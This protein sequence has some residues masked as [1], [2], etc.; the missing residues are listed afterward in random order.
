MKNNFALGLAP[1]KAGRQAAA[2]FTTG[3]LVA[4]TAVQT[5]AQDVKFGF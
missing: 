1:Y 3:C 5:G 2:Q 4:N